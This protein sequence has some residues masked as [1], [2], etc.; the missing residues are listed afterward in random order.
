MAAA[1]ALVLALSAVV[2]AGS[3]AHA[4][5]VTPAVAARTVTLITGDR[6]TLDGGAVTVT[7]GPGRS[8]I[9]MAT[10]TAG[11]RARVVPADALPL[12][13]ADKLD[14]RLFDVTGL[15]AAGYD[16]RRADLPLITSGGAA[17]SGARVRTLA[18]IGATAVRTPKR[19]LARDWKARTGAGKVWLDAKG[20]FTAAA[21]AQQIGAPLAWQ[22]G[23]TGAG[24]TVGVIDSGVDVTHPDLAPVVAAQTDFSTGTPTTEDVH[25]RLGHGTAVAS[26]LAG[27]GTA[28][29][30]RY[31]GV[32]PGVRLVSAKVGDFEVTESAVIAAMDWVAGAQRAKVVNMSLGFPNT[33]GNDPL[34]TAV[35]ELT[36]R[37]GTLFVVAAG[38]DGNNGNDP[39]NGDDYL[40]NS[41]ADAP[42]AL[43]VGAVDS[44]DRLADFSSRG[45]GLDGES[46][47]PE[48]TGPGVDI[49]HAL[50]VDAGPGPYEVGSGTSFAA[51]HVAGG[52]AI[53]AQKHPDWTPAQLKAGLMGAARPTDGLGA[54]SQGAGRIDVARAV[55]ATVVADPPSLSLGTQTAAKSVTYRNHGPRP[56]KLALRVT[57]PFTVSTTTLTVAAGGVAT[58]QVAVPATVTGGAHTGRLTATAGDQVVTTPVAVVR[59]RARAGLDLHVLGLDGL[60][61][62]DHYTQVIGLDTPYLHDSVFDYPWTPDL[63]LRVPTGRYAILTQY[64]AEAADGTYTSVAI[65][66]PAV[67]V[68]AA[69]D[70]T[71][72]TR[73][74]KPVT[75]T[76]PDAGA[77]FD[78]G[79][80]EFGVR[81]PTG[82]AAYA[83]NSYGGTLR[84]AQ[85]GGNG[86]ALTSLVRL[87][88]TSGTGVYHLAWPLK[89]RAPNGF[90]GTVTARDLAAETGEIGHQLT[91]SQLEMMAGVHVPGIPLTFAALT[92]DASANRYFSTAGGVSWSTGLYEWRE[93]EG[94]EEVRVVGEPRR[95]EA[96][97]EYTAA[98]NA[99]VIAP[100]L[101]GDGITWTGDRL[102]VRV[103]MDCDSA[104]HAGTTTGATGRTTLFRDGQQVAFADLAGEATLRAPRNRAGYRLRL[105]HSR[106]AVAVSSTASTVDWTFTD[107]AAAPALDTVRI[108]P[109]ASGVRLTP[110][111]GTRSMTLAASYDDGATWQAV[112]VRP[113]AGGTYRA[114]L[115]GTGYASLRMTAKG[116]AATVTETVIRALPP[117]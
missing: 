23:L 36:D 94:Y 90:T 88:Y 20:T 107:P 1:G 75:A 114:A 39:A 58:A 63:S 55:K 5:E 17:V 43:S 45:P 99:P 66:Q 18:G 42:A 44:D 95:Y 49:T 8:G 81:T 6:V 105:E 93:E 28:S 31:R 60:P 106:P 98:Y 110:P 38:N 96:G 9:P 115:T 72:D 85:L 70:I 62:E 61:T 56:L 10:S 109:L 29:D 100:C 68:T 30:G 12:L 50:S 26:I 108:E 78:A 51:P 57:A 89:G 67:T 33:P 103:A 116:A 46:I 65:A 97:R 79:A 64:F 52:A 113:G 111:A 34:E 32:A 7:P 84:S 69:T 21:G 19:N 3:A 13:R 117:A 83:A 2:V 14:A 48:I 53:L 37:Y 35:D 71:V 41:P 112:A 82:W 54:Y 59:E 86:D 101:T 74:A 92:T 80:V 91:G 25:D 73:T 24:V 104:G 16:D 102:R 76:L 40:I 27:Q 4:A 11:G 47:K 77:R 87:A 15:V 22:Q